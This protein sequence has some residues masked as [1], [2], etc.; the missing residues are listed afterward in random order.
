MQKLGDLKD[1]VSKINKTL[2]DTTQNRENLI[3]Q[4]NQD[5]FT[6]ETKFTQALS[7]ESNSRKDGESKLTKNIEEKF[8]SIRNDLVREGKQRT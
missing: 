8:Q 3:N 4:R 2:E 5:L 1:S 6:L 7:T